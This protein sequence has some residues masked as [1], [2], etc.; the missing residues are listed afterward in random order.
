[1]ETIVKEKER[2]TEV[3]EKRSKKLDKSF[4]SLESKFTFAAA[5]KARVHR[6]VLG[7]SQ[8]VCRGGFQDGSKGP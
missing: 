3:L 4:G 7:L 8:G 2:L 1:M 6:N 5:K